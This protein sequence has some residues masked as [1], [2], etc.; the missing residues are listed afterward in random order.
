MTVGLAG[1][2]P[3]VRPITWRL[4][5]GYLPANRDRREATLDRKR[6]EYKE[7]VTRYFPTRHDEE[8]KGLFHQICIDIPR[9]NP[10]VPTFQQEVVQKVG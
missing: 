1:I 7:F 8:N 3:S 9:T 10:S 4:L 6:A 2:P 5:S